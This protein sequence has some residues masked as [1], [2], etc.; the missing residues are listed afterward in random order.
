MFISKASF[1]HGIKVGLSNDPDDVVRVQFG[2]HE[3][4]FSMYFS[5]NEA[6]ELLS[7][8]EKAIHQTA[9]VTNALV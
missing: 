5:R 9:E 3:E 6:L 1:A 8:L 4:S 7:G 2:T